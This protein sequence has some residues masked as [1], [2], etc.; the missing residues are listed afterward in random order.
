MSKLKA[1]TEKFQS[2]RIQDTTIAVAS[3]EEIETALVELGG[4]REDLLELLRDTPIEVRGA[5][6]SREQIQ[7]LLD[8]IVRETKVY[9]QFVGEDRPKLSLEAILGE[10]DDV[11][12]YNH[13]DWEQ[14]GEESVIE[15]V[16]EERSQES[17]SEVSLDEISTTSTLSPSAL[18]FAPQLSL[19]RPPGFRMDSLAAQSNL[20]SGPGHSPEF[21]STTYP[22]GP[23]SLI[24]SERGESS[25]ATSPFPPFERNLTQGDSNFIP[26]GPLDVFKWIPL[27]KLNDQI[28]ADAARQNIGMLTVFAVRT[29]IHIGFPTEAK[30]KVALLCR[31]TVL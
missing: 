19:S 21:T 11:S 30:L 7:D 24:S 8:A 18:G 9:E 22:V 12:L 28:F 29:G 2:T 17:T 13:Q 1:I 27:Q 15:N 26:S 10:P 16:N 5:I 31:S 4:L 20:G 23:S 6:Q 3:Q 25:L 14:D